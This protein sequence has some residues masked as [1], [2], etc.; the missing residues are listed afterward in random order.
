MMPPGGRVRTALHL[1]CLSYVYLFIYFFQ[2]THQ[3]DWM[4]ARA[5]VWFSM[6][7]FFLSPSSFRPSLQIITPLDRQ[8]LISPLFPPSSFPL[9]SSALSRRIFRAYDRRRSVRKSW[10]R[11]SFPPLLSLPYG[12]LR[13]ARPLLLPTCPCFSSS[14]CLVAP[15]A[16][17][18][19]AALI[20]PLRASS[21]CFA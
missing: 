16:H 19:S 7:F 1:T 8:T 11:G 6:T 10:Q 21:V 2:P 14:P 13:S 5:G 12:T 15:L 9:H 4:Q 18:I 17:C 3:P 20:R